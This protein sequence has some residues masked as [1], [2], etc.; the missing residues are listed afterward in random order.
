MSNWVAIEKNKGHWTERT[1]LFRD[2]PRLNMSHSLNSLKGDYILWFIIG[3]IKGDTRSLDNGS[4]VSVKPESSAPHQDP[5][6]N[7]KP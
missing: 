4:Y 7:P 1:I 2:N 6:L 5:P 3:V